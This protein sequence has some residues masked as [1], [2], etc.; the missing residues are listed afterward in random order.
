MSKEVKEFLDGTATQQATAMDTEPTAN[1]ALLKDIVKKQVDCQ[2]KK[3]QAEINKLC[4]QLARSIK[5]ADKNDK[6]NISWGANTKKPGAPSTK[7]MPP[8]SPLKSALK[9]HGTTNQKG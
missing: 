9:K 5:P 2:Q 8:S 6:K 1:P 3:M 4:Q 7:K